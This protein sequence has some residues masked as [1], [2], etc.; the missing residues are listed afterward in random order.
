M[1]H[2]ATVGLHL[3]VRQNQL[4]H[5]VI[6]RVHVTQG[7]HSKYEKI[8]DAGRLWSGSGVGVSNLKAQ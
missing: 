2:I 4:Q 8:D 1:H 6:A 7:H 3:L 5:G